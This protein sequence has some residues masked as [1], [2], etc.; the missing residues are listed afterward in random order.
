MRKHL[1]VCPEH[2]CTDLTCGH[3]AK[4][5]DK[6]GILAA[7]LNVPGMDVEK[8]CRPCFKLPY[9]ATPSFPNPQ[10]WIK[11]H[12][13]QVA[14]KGMKVCKTQIQYNSW[15][16]VNPIDV[17]ALRREATKVPTR[18]FHKSIVVSLASPLKIRQRALLFKLPQWFLSLM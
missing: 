8:A 1:E 6:W 11:K 4:H 9:V 12:A 3:C 13:L 15:R 7:H 5:F 2:K 10:N 14:R 17:K 16:N 18:D